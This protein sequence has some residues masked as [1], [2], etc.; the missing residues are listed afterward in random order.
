MLKILAACGNGQGS[1][2]IIK[3]R[4][5]KVLNKKGIKFKV[6][7]TSVG[8][9]KASAKSYDLVL[10]SQQFVSNFPKVPDSTKIVG[11]KNLMD[12]KEIETKVTEAMGW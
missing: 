12:M 7:H 10:V 6:D 8:E 9:A 3:M 4:I 5:E 2:A 11:L 1:S